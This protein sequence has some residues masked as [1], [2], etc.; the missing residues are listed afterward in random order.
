MNLTFQ[1]AEIKDADPIFRLAQQ[2]VRE[3]EDAETVD[4]GEVEAWMQRKI[5]LKIQ[6]YQRIVLSGT[7]VGYFRMEDQND[8]TELDDFYILPEYRSQGIGTQ[9][10]LRCM[11]QAKNPIYFYVFNENQDAIRFYQRCGFQ[12]VSSVSAT[13]SIMSEKVDS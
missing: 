1:Q 6:S 2:L 8:R 3:F 12:I 9:V 11:E 4:L 13:R 5:T 7:V 10:L